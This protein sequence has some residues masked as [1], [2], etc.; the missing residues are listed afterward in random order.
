MDKILNYQNRLKQ[1]WENLEPFDEDEHKIPD[2]PVVDGTYCTEELWNDYVLPSLIRCGAIPKCKLKIGQW[3]NGD[4]RNA[5]CA[6]W[7][8]KE[9]EYERCKWNFYFKDKVNH[10][11]DAVTDDFALFIPIKEIDRPKTLHLGFYLN[12]D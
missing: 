1:Y 8:G 12:N 6:M 11:E 7:N 5:S 10:F 9:F 2:L 4:T 3:Y